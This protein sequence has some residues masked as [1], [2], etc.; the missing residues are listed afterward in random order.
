MR[1]R[2]L[3]ACTPFARRLP[4]SRREYPPRLCLRRLMPCASARLAVRFE[5][6][7]AAGAHGMHVSTHGAAY[8]LFPTSESSLAKSSTDAFNAAWS[9]SGSI[10]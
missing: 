2:C 10:L 6:A 4:A 5:S 1:C 3:A 8:V 9:W 7:G